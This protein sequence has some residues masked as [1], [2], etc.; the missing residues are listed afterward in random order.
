[1]MQKKIL[2]IS[3]ISGKQVGSFSMASIYAAHETGM[4]FHI[5]SNFNQSSKEQQL[6][7]E[8]QYGIT[9]HQI[10]FI[11]NPLNLKNIRAY[12]QLVNLIKREGIDI[13]HCNTP[14][15]GVCGRLA[16]KKCGVKKI[17]YQVHGFH[18]YKGA[19]FVN[20]TLFKWAEKILAHWTDVIITI[21]QED[22]EAARKFNLRNHGKVYYVPGVGIDCEMYRSVEVNRDEIRLSL[23]LKETDIVC[24]SMGDLI[25]RKNYS[26][27]IKAIAKCDNKNIQYLICGKG[28][29]L[30]NLQRLSKE[31]NIS[32]RVHF[33]GFRSDIKELLKAS[34]IFLFTTLQEGM[35]RSMMEA[36]A[37]GLPCVASK[38]RGNVDLLEDEKSGYLVNPCDDTII[39]E[40]LDI[41]SSDEELRKKWL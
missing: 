36:M 12:R 37:S 9:I 32:D 13:I 38:I 30:E 3:N 28:G 8:K 20:C 2:F 34:D 40:K 39:A 17:I 41:L 14:I 4:E 11:R 23:G 7:D 24:I 16:G 1:M 31:E 26:T 10:D 18:F 19:S 35:P 6:Q 21:N 5:A 25:P 27:A 15:G 22:Y 29:E 33:L